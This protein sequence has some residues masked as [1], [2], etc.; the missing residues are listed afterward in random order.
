L[1]WNTVLKNNGLSGLQISAI[2]KG[3]AEEK[4]SLIDSKKKKVD[5][6]E[7]VSKTV[8]RKDSGTGCG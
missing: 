8:I 2:Y 3:E 6:K 5:R 1:G 4:N 7:K